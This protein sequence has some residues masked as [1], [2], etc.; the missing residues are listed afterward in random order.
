M[1]LPR[2][3]SRRI[4][5]AGLGNCLLADDGVGVHA[6]REL[7]R[8]RPRGFRAIEV[9]TAV[10]DAL[11]LFEEADHVIAIDAMQAG[12]TPGD[13][14]SFR[15]E[16]VDDP[17]GKV[18]LHD[19]GLRS[20]FHFMRGTKRPEVLVLGVEPLTLDYSLDL[21]EPVARALPRLIEEAHKIVRNWRRLLIRDESGTFPRRR[22]LWDCR[23]LQYL[24]TLKVDLP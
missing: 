4:L 8:R 1:T 5:V 17:V 10:L 20:V 11:H 3:S 19:Y 24:I 13:I 12:G 23:K 21:T 18:S 7:K 2:T 22:C 16:D 9:G 6:V 15:L 14:Y